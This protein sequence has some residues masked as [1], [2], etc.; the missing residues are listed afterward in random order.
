MR[1]MTDDDLD[2]LEDEFIEEVTTAATLPSGALPTLNNGKLSAHAAEFWFPESR[3]CECC[4]GFK[5]GCPCTKA[6]FV[7]CQIPGC[8]ME[9]HRAKM[10]TVESVPRSAP[11]ISLKVGPAAGGDDSNTA[12]RFEL[13]AQGCRFGA[14]CRFRHSN[15]NSNNQFQPPVNNN[16]GGATGNT[17]KPPCQHF[18]RGYCMFGENCRFGHY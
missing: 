2:E 11:T 5:H 8:V 3:D 13:S 18:S 12:C 14:T 4:R 1:N 9:E 10:K 16:V 7:A 6:G 17:S 15:N